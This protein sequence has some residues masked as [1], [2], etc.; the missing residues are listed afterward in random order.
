MMVNPGRPPTAFERRVYA[1]TAAIPQGRV[2]T[3]ATL[4]AVLGSTGATR[5]V[6][7]ALRRNP[8]APTVPCHRVVAAGGKLGGFSGATEGPNIQRK[9]RLLA[10]EGV[11]VADGA[12]AASAL[13]TPAELAR[14][15][16]A[17]AAPACLQG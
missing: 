10:G 3:Y 2:A 1:L 16:Q 6:G 8:F 15:A 12:C 13:L 17:A 7:Q 11:A 4:A 9:I 5:A 14:A